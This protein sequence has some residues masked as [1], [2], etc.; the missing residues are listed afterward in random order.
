MPKGASVEILPYA[1]H[2]LPELWPNPD[3][4]IPDR[5][6]EPTHHPY[7][8]LPF[9]GGHRLCIGQRFALNEMRM[10]LAKLVHKF[11]FNPA[12]PDKQAKLEYFVGSVLM[13]PK[14]LMVKLKARNSV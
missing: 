11:E 4:F 5:F 9:G 2:R 3:A 12:E 6:L 14:E 8:Y 13:S 1:L 10:C 7:A